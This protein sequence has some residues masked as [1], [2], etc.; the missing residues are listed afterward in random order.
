MTAT[1]AKAAA[2]AGAVATALSLAMAT[3]GGALGASSSQGAASLEG[4]LT[5][6]TEGCVTGG[7]V[8]GLSAQ[9]AAMAARV[10]AAAFAVS[11]EDLAA[12]R[13][14]LMTAITESGLA[15]LG[16]RSGN[17]G[18]LGLFQQRAAAGWGTPAEELDPADATGMFVSR[19]LRV[20]GWASMP[21]W[22]AAQVVQRSSFTGVPSASNGGSSVVGGNY[23]AHWA[24]SGAVLAAV[25]GHDT[26]GGCG[27]GVP[28]GVVGPASGH[29]LPAGYQIPAGTGPAHAAAV[30][31]ALAQL[32]KAY[33]WAAAGPAAYD[34]SGLTMAAW[35]A[36]GVTL[37]HYTVDQQHE[38]VP[39]SAAGLQAGDLVL[40]P[41]SDS[42][43]PGLAGHV[44]IYL[45]YGLVESAVDPQ[46]GVV[47]QSWS[48]F[49]SGGLDAL[50][51]PDPA[52]G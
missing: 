22:A 38:G 49:V 36:A 12:A 16:P 32:G 9:Q 35:A 18:S 10:V 28:G 39:V 34:C 30:R 37:A 40:T 4:V 52:D 5:S 21:P 25:V 48:L 31:F 43:G 1:A 17:D 19:L 11:G 27:Q 46:V 47:V 45:G 20:P 7:S 44:G 2:M 3:L 8:T 41:G 42:P 23:R 29:G 14:A 13:I 26:T 50:V 33:V 24:A 15:D 6:A 51:D